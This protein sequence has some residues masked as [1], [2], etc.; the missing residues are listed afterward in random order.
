[1][2]ADL[3]HQA[4]KSGYRSTEFWLSTLSTLLGV[5]LA[6]GI[7]PDGGMVAQIIGGTL[8]VLSQLGYVSSRTAVKKTHAAVHT[9]SE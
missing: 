6:S 2:T 3:N 1:M 9:T 4:L 7:V 8:T 5:L